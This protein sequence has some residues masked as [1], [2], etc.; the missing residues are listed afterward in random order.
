MDMKLFQNNPLYIIWFIFYFTLAWLMTGANIVSFFVVL[1]MYIISIR[2][3]FSPIG[4]QILRFLNGTRQLETRREKEYLIPLFEDVYNEAKLFDKNLIQNIEIC[5]IDA[6]YINAVALGQKTV[7]VTKGAVESLSEE[8]LKGFIA[9]ELGHIANGDT[10][11]L[12]LTIIGNGIFSIFIVISKAIIN[13]ITFGTETYDRKGF[14]GFI[15]ILSK[16]LFDIMLFFFLF[17]GQVILSI[18]SRKNEFNADEFA[19][20]IGYGEPL[21]DALYLLQDMCISDKMNLVQKLKASHPHIAKRI[22]RL[23]QIEN[24]YA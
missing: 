23:E 20:K 7:A 14:F 2:I 12:L 16:F 11:A 10:K 6:M 24:R 5:I 3:A 19:Y 18:N 1:I 8:E 17:L 22:G 9:H 13:I 21:I 4:E 15:M